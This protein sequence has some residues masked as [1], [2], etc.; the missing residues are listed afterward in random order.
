MIKVPDNIKRATQW[1]EVAWHLARIEQ[2]M[3]YL[4]AATPTGRQRELLTEANIHRMAM[5][6]VLQKALDAR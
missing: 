2:P 5:E 3:D 1:H 6:A 4:I